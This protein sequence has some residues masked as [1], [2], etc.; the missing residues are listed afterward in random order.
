[1]KRNS[2]LETPVPLSNGLY[3][4]FHTD[5]WVQFT[6]GAFTGRLES[7]RVAV[8]RDGRG[9]TLDHGFVERRGRAVKYEDVYLQGY[10][11]VPELRRG[12]ARYFAFSNHAR[13]H[14]VLGY[15]TPAAVSETP[16]P[17]I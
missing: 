10:E 14:Q 7:A 1:L 3:P 4:V 12:L 17:R 9:R 15:R 5:Q 11:E 2:G 16:W 8:S 6:A 13:L